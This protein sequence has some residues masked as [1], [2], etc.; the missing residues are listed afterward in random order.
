MDTGG[1]VSVLPLSLC[2]KLKPPVNPPVPTREVATYGNNTVKFHGPVPLHVQLCGLTILHPF[3]IVDDSKAGLAPAIGGYDLM[4]SGCM[5]LDIDN[6]LLWS[7]LTYSLTEQPSPNPTT[8]IPNTN[9]RCVVCF[10]ELPSRDAEP[11]AVL[12]E[13]DAVDP[14]PA[15]VASE[16]ST[17]LR[18]QVKTV[19]PPVGFRVPILRPVLSSSAPVFCPRADRR[20]PTGT[21]TKPHTAFRVPVVECD[22][23]LLKTHVGP[24]HMFSMESTDLTVPSHLQGL[25]DKSVAQGD[26]AST[27][28][29]NLAALLRRHSDAFATGPMNLG[30]CSVL[31]HDIDTGDAEPI[32]QPPR[33]PPLSARQAEEDILNEML[34]TGMIEPS[35]SPWSSPVC[36]VR[37]KDGSYRYCVDYRRMNS[38]TIKD[39]FPVPDVKDALD[40]LRGAKYFA[41]ID[42]LSVYWQLGMT[43]RARERSAFCTRRGL[44]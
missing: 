22:D 17:V 26:L 30:Y 15:S 8:S 24:S 40:S 7:R 21:T 25:F 23:T 29:C 43:Q 14:D 27:H 18:R 41:T 1:Q 44:Y 33:R 39:A 10:A 16:R 3:Y 9:V 6:Q 36:M 19:L 20:P 31:E 12:S 35:N 5:V 2:Q 34:Q 11:S 13:P 28:Q 42:L 38:V 37:K 32:R 4:K